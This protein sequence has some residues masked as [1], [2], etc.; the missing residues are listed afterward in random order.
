M[1]NVFLHLRECI[2]TFLWRTMWFLNV[3]LVVIQNN[4]KNIDVLKIT[5][6]NKI[7]LHQKYPNLFYPQ[8]SN[9]EKRLNVIFT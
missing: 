4:N 8:P 6:K 7:T 2:S 1:I 3:A 5:L 9:G